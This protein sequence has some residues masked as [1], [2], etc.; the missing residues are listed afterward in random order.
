MREK[1][2]AL[3]D[4]RKWVWSGMFLAVGGGPLRIT[5]MALLREVLRS[6]VR[7]LDLLVTPT[8]GLGVDMLI[9]AG[10]ARSVEFA[11]IVLD[12]F[13]MAPH[14]RR[15]AEAGR[16]RCKDHTCPA[17]LSGLQ[18]AAMGIPFI[19]VRG[20]IGSDYLRVRP[21]FKVVQDP[22]SG[23]E[24]VVVPPLAPDLALIHAIKGDRYGNLLLER[25]ED[26]QLLI[27]AAKRVVAS[28]EEL[29]EPEE[30]RRSPEGVWVPSL[31]VDAIIPLP[32]GAHPTDCRGYYPIDE[33]HIR[34]YLE[35][36]QSP[37]AFQEYL[38]RYVY[39]AADHEA[40]LEV[41]GSK[42]TPA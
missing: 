21:E 42:A 30:L 17:L 23:E 14:F 18:A 12:E 37:E 33:D 4:L 29:V 22:Y 20:L 25:T 41:I 19:P 9:G 31:Y 24:I 2:C 27:R 13:G 39:R 1:L 40:Y 38:E 15:Q 6:G 7:D 28:V 26:D 16:L 3:Q 11:Q 8:G 36:S 10:V 35:A 32:Y 5:P 34:E